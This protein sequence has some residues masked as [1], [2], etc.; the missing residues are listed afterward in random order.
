MWVLGGWLLEEFLP[1][2]AVLD[3]LHRGCTFAPQFTVSS[4]QK[5]CEEKAEAM[6]R[7]GSREN[8][9]SGV[10]PFLLLCSSSP[11]A[12]WDPTLRGVMVWYFYLGSCMKV[13]V[14]L[15]KMWKNPSNMK[16]LAFWLIE[17]IPLFFYFWLYHVGRLEKNE[18]SAVFFLY[19]LTLYKHLLTIIYKDKSV[20]VW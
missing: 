6:W 10:W 2:Q 11:F 15:I 16:I 19:A 17:A 20:N 12:P 7:K 14:R 1:D 8:P 13:E 18:E 4:G 9:S 5:P 3:P